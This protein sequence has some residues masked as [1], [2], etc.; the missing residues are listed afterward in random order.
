[1]R[2]SFPK[3]PGKEKLEFESAFNKTMINGEWALC[4][5]RCMARKNGEWIQVWETKQF[6]LSI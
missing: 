6:S 5:G 3:Y 2:T 1:M 4:V